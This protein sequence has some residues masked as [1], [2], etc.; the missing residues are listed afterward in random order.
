MKRDFNNPTAAVQAAAHTALLLNDQRTAARLYA[1]WALQ[2]SD[3][4]GGTGFL[5]PGDLDSLHTKTRQLMDY[6][7]L[8]TDQLDCIC[9]LF[10][11]FPSFGSICADFSADASTPLLDPITRLRWDIFQRLNASQSVRN[12][13]QKIQLLGQ[14]QTLARTLQR[15]AANQYRSDQ[16]KVTLA[17]AQAYADWGHFEQGNTLSVQHYEQAAG[18]L[19]EAGGFSTPALEAARREALVSVYLSLG[20]THFNAGRLNRA[21]SALQLG[22]Q[23]ANRLLGDGS[24]GH[25]LRISNELVGPLYLLLGNARLLEGNAQAARQAFD[26]ANNAYT[27]GIN[28]YCFGHV[29]LL[30]G[31]EIEA[32]LNYGGI[33]NESQLGQACFE[34]D[35]MAHFLP[36]QRGRLVKFAD[37]IRA[38]RLATNSQLD[39]NAVDYYRATQ[40]MQFQAATENRDAAF[41][42]S[43]DALQFVEKILAQPQASETWDE[44]HLRAVLNWSYYGLLAAKQNKPMLTRLIDAITDHQKGM[45]QSYFSQLKILLNTNLAP[46]YWLRGEPGDQDL[47]LEA[48]R[49]FLVEPLQQNDPWEV[50]LKDFRD[51]L[52]TGVAWPDLSGLIQK[53]KP[54]DAF[55]SVDDWRDLQLTPPER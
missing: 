44:E 54:P 48:Y 35:Q 45:M 9:G 47:A 50:L 49:N 16:E 6:D 34:I 33:F 20:A 17:L 1:A 7:L 12:H 5:T 21:V 37:R 36:G 19:T 51:I 43:T 55:M 39:S 24:G 28:S 42:R 40:H 3:R 2:L 41:S 13:R 23:E 10:G 25:S 14:T 30:E 31:D 38:A 4:R 8:D 52:R 15:R 18:L 26:A 53:I 22:L 29:A 11:S 27:E 32:L 46:A